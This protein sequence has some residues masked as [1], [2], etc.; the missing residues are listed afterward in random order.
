MALLSTQT[1]TPAGIVPAYTAVAASDTFR[2]KRGTFVEVVNGGAG[3]TTVTFDSVTLSNYG[4]DADNVVTVAAGATKK[5]YLGDEQA[6]RYTSPL[7]GVAT[8]TCSPTTSVTI[9]VFQ[10]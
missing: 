3:T 7:T 2:A 5:I 1:I 8:V 9:G 4:T 10:V 6:A